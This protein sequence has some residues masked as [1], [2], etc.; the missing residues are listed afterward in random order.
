MTTITAFLESTASL[1]AAIGALLTGLAAVVG[2]A[3]PARR[4]RSTNKE[5]VSS[6]AIFQRSTKATVA[7]GLFLILISLGLFAGRALSAGKNVLNNELVSAAFDALNKDDFPRAIANADRCISE[8]GGAADQEQDKLEKAKIPIPG[9]GKV[10]DQE[11]QVIFSRGLLNDV[12]T[13]FFIKGKAAESLGQQGIAISSYEEAARYTYARCWDPNG[14]F[15]SPSEA[16]K[17]RLAGLK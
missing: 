1:I 7:I 3:K 4:T 9:T 2:A 8:F 13:C 10:P 11:K 5:I 12:A 6:M 14:W 15:W 17:G 16:A